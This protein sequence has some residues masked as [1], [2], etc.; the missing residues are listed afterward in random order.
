M[1]IL[2]NINLSL[3]E[4]RSAKLEILASDPTNTA[5][6]IWWNSTAGR[7]KVSNGSAALTLIT[8]GA[9]FANGD[10]PLAK[11]ATDPLAR[12]GHTGTQAAST[13]SDLATVVQAYRL[14]Q[15]AAPTA[16]VSMG[17]QRITNVATPTTGTDAANKQYVDDA[18]AGLSWKDEV[19]AATTANIT[20]S[21][22]QTID[23]VS[24]VAS[25]RVL[26]KDQSTA[27]QNGIYVASAGA[28]SRAPDSDTAGE[29]QGAAVYVKGGTVNGGGRYVNNTTGTI[30]L[31]STALTFVQFAGGTTYSAGAGLT[32]TGA[33]FDVGA[34]TGITVGSDTVAVDTAVVARWK[35]GTITGDGTTTSFAYSHNLNNQYPAVTVWE[36][37]SPLEQVF[38]LVKATDVN[39]VT[40]QF[41]V[42]PTGGLAYKVSVAG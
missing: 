35:V 18:V 38:P 8:A 17:S 24:V 33:T 14:D 6:R 16:A 23:G 39:T 11:L 13:I 30:T 10:I 9:D 19:V 41:A 3:N 32:L 12:G 22:A 27:S 26:V 25:D 37:A 2:D 20:L 7:A 42:A 15:F 5:A 29:I 31:G 4:I 21:G 1:K 40:I 34:G 36:A 28:W